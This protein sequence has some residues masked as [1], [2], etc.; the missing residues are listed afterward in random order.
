MAENKVRIEDELGNVYYPHTKA[1][2]TFMSDG[3][4][5]EQHA[6]NK[7]N[8]HAVTKMQVGLG[9]VENYAVA[10]QAEAEAGTANNKYMTPQRAK[11]AFNKNITPFS[12]SLEQ[13]ET[14]VTTHLDKYALEQIDFY[15]TD[16]GSDNNNGLTPSTPVKTNVKLNELL[17]KYKS[18][19]V[20]N[21]NVITELSERIVIDNVDSTI[22]LKSLAGKSIKSKL[23]FSA[24]NCRC[25]LVFDVQCITNVDENL[26]SF[27]NVGNVEIARSKMQ[28]LS[29]GVATGISFR[30]V[31]NFLVDSCEGSYLKTFIN[32]HNSSGLAHQISGAS[33][34]TGYV[35]RYGSTLTVSGSV[36]TATTLKVEEQGG[37]IR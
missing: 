35:S 11:Q 22:V 29:G 37:V 26:L 23:K 27:Y 24:N 9:N 14:Q 2:V 5:I 31:G 36:L 15:I 33:N 19:K 13:L 6:G 7:N 25:I 8:P 30:N 28:P 10:T 20:I 21:I 18:T 16:S 32:A 1:D 34:N 4:T 17:A 12:N 3:T